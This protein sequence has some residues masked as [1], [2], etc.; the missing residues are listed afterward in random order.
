MCRVGNQDLLVVE[1]RGTRLKQSV[2]HLPSGDYC[3]P[4]FGLP[5]SLRDGFLNFPG[6]LYR[7][8]K[9]W[10]RKTMAPSLT[11]SSAFNASGRNASVGADAP[12]VQGWVNRVANAGEDGEDN[13]GDGGEEDDNDED[14]EDEGVTG[15][16]RRHASVG[17]KMRRPMVSCALQVYAES[18]SM[19][20]APS[21]GPET[22]Q[23]LQP[24]V[25]ESEPSQ[26]QRDRAQS[27]SSTNRPTWVF[28]GILMQELR[29]AS[30]MP[31]TTAFGKF[32][33]PMALPVSS[34]RLPVVTCHYNSLGS[35]ARGKLGAPEAKNPSTVIPHI[36][37]KRCNDPDALCLSSLCHAPRSMSMCFDL[38]SPT[39]TCFVSALVI[40]VCVYRAYTSAGANLSRWLSMS[41]CYATVHTR[42]VDPPN[43]T[44]VIMTIWGLGFFR[45]ERAD[46][47]G[48]M[49]GS[50]VFNV[51]GLSVGPQF[52]SELGLAGKELRDRSTRLQ[53][54]ES[55]LEIREQALAASSRCADT[56]YSREADVVTFEISQSNGMPFKL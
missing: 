53:E 8:R 26:N 43:L 10:W 44:C 38:S 32:A 34:A 36:L 13:E 16:E 7:C 56:T 35:W 14:E 54:N 23:P 9:P 1:C 24:P 4:V 45:H 27:V 52:H 37:A 12:P 22:A 33:S 25:R 55:E 5:I 18:S 41:G 31:R 50:L 51:G 40:N 21:S 6:P 28:Y 19:D 17:A 20:F 2:Y 29:Q 49:G 47:P 46:A 11:S 39:S 15:G 42:I 48:E 3:L 30:G